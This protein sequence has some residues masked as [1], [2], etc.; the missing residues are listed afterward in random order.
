MTLRRFR[1]IVAAIRRYDYLK[2]REQKSLISWQTR[3][4]ATYIAAG[5]QVAENQENEA[6]K[7]ASELAIDHIEESRIREE[8]AFADRGPEIKKEEGPAVGSYEMFLGT[9]GSPKRW[10]GS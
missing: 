5:F 9:F 7:A 8:S 6:L 2:A 10:A 3:T 1:Q 4:L